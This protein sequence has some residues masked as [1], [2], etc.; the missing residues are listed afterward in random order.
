MKYE[1]DWMRKSEKNK[2]KLIKHAAE[3]KEDLLKSYESEY[4]SLLLATEKKFIKK[5]TEIIKTKKEYKHLIVIGIGGSNLGTLAI[6]EAI[7]GKDHLIHNNKKI[8]FAD[9]TDPDNITSIKKQVKNKKFLVLLISKSGT[10]TESLANFEVILNEIPKQE[11]AQRIITIT[12]KGT[13]LEKYSNK[14]KYTCLEIPKKIGGRFSVLSYVGLLPLAFAEIKIKN[15]LKGASDAIKSFDENNIAMEGALDLHHNYEH[16]KKINNIFL[17]NNDL[18][19]L[20]KWYRQ[21]M[22]ESIGK[23]HTKTK[24]QAHIGITPT[25]SIGSTDL[26]SVGQLY[27]GGPKD[28]FT[29]FISLE[30]Q[31]KV[32]IPKNED[33][34]LKNIQGLSFKK[35]LQAIMQ[36]TMTAYKKNKLPYN[37]YTLKEKTEYE[38][39]YF[40]Q[41][42]MLEIILLAHLLNVNPF[43]Q[44]SVEEY[45][46]ETRKILKT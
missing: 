18:E 24:R 40:M 3:I 30:K 25:V 32:I 13:E 20:G 35:I 1:K 42:K 37:H 14:K 12:D 44:P 29:T 21:L 39:G 34:I 17:F 7:H 16:N 31:T 38:L 11:R 5:V 8:F 27:M 36:G 23:K 33:A 10:T 2:N 28:K 46:K 26:H 19:S 9:T 41:T 43:D 4:A 45:K 6:I 22:G 15:L